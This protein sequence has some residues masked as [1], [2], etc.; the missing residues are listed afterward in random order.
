MSDAAP[1]PDALPSA[2]GV[3]RLLRA[4][5][6]RNYRLY[7]TGQGISL[8][9]TWLTRIA[10]SW[11]VY[12]LTKSAELLGWVGF[13]GQIP[14]FILAPFAG[15]IVDRRNKH[16]IMVITQ[17]LAMLQSAA[18]AVLA[19]GH[20]IRV[21]H[22]LVLSIV[23]GLINTFDM[24]ARQAFMIDLV[25]H[26]DD[27]SNAIALNSSMVN[28]SR[29]IGPAMAGV[30][31]GLF[32][33]GMCFAI[34]AASYIA[35]VAALLMM[36]LPPYRPRERK[37]SAWNEMGEGLKYSFGFPPI[38][39][40]LILL[41]AMS[42]LGMSYTVLMPVFA[43]Q[44]L[45]GGPKTLG[46]LMAASGIG[47]LAGALYLASRT[48]VVGLGRVISIAGV[49]FGAALIAFGFSH[50]LWLSLLTLLIGGGAMLINFASAN[51][52]LQ[53]ITK[54]ELRGRVMSFF[55]MAF[56][57]MA[58]FGSLLSGLLS[59]RIG[60]GMTVVWSGVCCIIV[61]GIFA[62][63]IPALRI[64]VRPIYIEKGILR[65]VAQGLQAA[66]DMRTGPEED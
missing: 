23:Q 27:L 4:L 16:R 64:L 54:D 25:E 10:T 9:G 53:T 46:F 38:R 12:D 8:I 28:G 15:A 32:G 55:G 7:F 22:I 11:L 2:N 36:R 57:G 3:P 44:V 61:S 47:A 24:P 50:H 17:I 30:L 13:A 26:R 5:S 60:P 49:I 43:T 19:L 21:W 66:T 52:I 42:L 51:T 39:A 45:H 37:S 59:D 65:E 14:T 6:S 1:I 20:W 33:T 41:A 48:T 56:M 63:K 29:L 62:A 58:P 18:L 34:D 40:V 31:I 35:V